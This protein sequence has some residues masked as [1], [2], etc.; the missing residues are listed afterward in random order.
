MAFARIS[1]SAVQAGRMPRVCMCCGQRAE[2]MVE[3]RFYYDPA[4]LMAISLILPR[5]ARLISGDNSVQLMAPLCNAHKRRLKL[6]GY[7]GYALAVVAL[8]FVPLLIYLTY[9]QQATLQGVLAVVMN[10]RAIG[11]YLDDG[12]RKPKRAPH[13][14]HLVAASKLRTWRKHVRTTRHFC[15]AK[16]FCGDGRPFQSASSLRRTRGGVIARRRRW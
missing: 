4:Y 13:R 16:T 11:G 6:P 15:L 5:L 2:H 8:L 1:Q 10:L 3:H 14:P 12:G 7:L 9:A